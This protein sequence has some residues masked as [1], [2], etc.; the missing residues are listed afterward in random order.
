M[1]IGGESNL[2][3][4]TLSIIRKGHIGDVILTEPIANYFRSKGY[5]VT[6]VTEYTQVQPLLTTYHDVL[7]YS[8]LENMEFSQVNTIEIAYEYYPSLSYIDGY[9]AYSG[10]TLERKYPSIKSLGSSLISDPYFL[11]APHTSSWLRNSRE[12]PMEKFEELA[13][14]ITNDIQINAVFLSPHHTFVDMAKLIEHCHFFIG[15]DSAP[16]ILAQCYHRQSFIIFGSTE[17]SKVIFSSKVVP[18][19]QN[20]GCNGCIQYSRNS[21]T[22]CNTPL[23]LSDMQPDQ[24]AKHIISKVKL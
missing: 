8:I 6:L 19:V 16:G 11:V 10:I 5:Y 13:F 4:N 23:C 3:E 9:A 17:P 14:L 15:N 18:L 20:I 21:I 7:P 1:T 24:L 22:Q 12:W 2:N